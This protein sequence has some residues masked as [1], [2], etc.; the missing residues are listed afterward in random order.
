MRLADLFDDLQTKALVMK[1]EQ[2]ARDR[3]NRLTPQQ[4]VIVPLMTDGL[5]SKQIAHAIG[6]S[7]RTVENHRLEI[8]RRSDCRTIPELTRLLMLAG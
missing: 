3:L 7:Q 6:I 8:M 5:L 4:R 2:D 1:A